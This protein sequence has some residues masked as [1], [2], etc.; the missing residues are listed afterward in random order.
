[1]IKLPIRRLVC[2]ALAAT[3]ILGPL[4]RAVAAPTENERE[5]EVKLL[6]I[7]NRAREA[8]D[9][10]RLKEHDVIVEEA[11]AQSARM[12]EAGELNH[13][14]LDARKNR[15]AKADEGIDPE[16]ICEAVASARSSNIGKSMKKIFK[17]WRAAEEQ[18]SCVLDGSG[19]T[20]R[21]AGVGVTFADGTFWV[22]YI[23][24]SDDTP[25]GK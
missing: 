7:I 14:G 10:K 1:V 2:V 3:A 25:G 12:A 19:Y 24:A 15:I 11:R 5:A 16:Q 22:T 4:P 17:S 8:Q 23:G 13:A 9:L 6:K 18:R 20:T 21:S